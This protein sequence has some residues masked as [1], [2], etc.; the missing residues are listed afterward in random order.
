MKYYFLSLHFKKII[1]KKQNVGT[2]SFSK[3]IISVF[4]DRQMK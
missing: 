3:M 2:Y 1:E 4:S